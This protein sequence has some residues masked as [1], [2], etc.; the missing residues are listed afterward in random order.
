M[1]T[2]KEKQKFI[3]ESF[4]K[5]FDMEIEYKGHRRVISSPS[6]L[7]SNYSEDDKIYAYHISGY[8]SSGSDRERS[9]FI[10]YMKII[11]LI[12]KSEE[13]QEYL[14]KLGLIAKT[15]ILENFTDS[16]G[17]KNDI[18][19]TIITNK[20]GEV[21]YTLIPADY[22]GAY[23]L[24]DGKCDDEDEIDYILGVD[25]YHIIDGSSI[26]NPEGDDDFENDGGSSKYRFYSMYDVYLAISL[27]KAKKS[28]KR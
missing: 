24:F 12:S 16:I 19:I 8:T 18:I 20:K 23:A 26:K 15:K 17:H 3:T 21:Q 2:I 6:M 25:G 5:G 4:Y 13:L 14:D 22:A 11:R 7:S 10:K 1:Q 27:D 9:F 28:R